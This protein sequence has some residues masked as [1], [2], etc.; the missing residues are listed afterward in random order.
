MGR[1]TQ[2]PKR[3]SEATVRELIIDLGTARP[4]SPTEL[5]LLLERSVRKLVDKHL[6][7]LV[8]EGRLE[9]THEALT[10]P[11]QSYRATAGGA[12]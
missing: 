4:W 12:P 11:D 1:N 7:P 9:R 2:L 5:S 6:T 10:H 8:R 3:A